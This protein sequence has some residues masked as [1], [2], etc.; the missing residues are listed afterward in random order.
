LIRIILVIVETFY[1]YFID[2]KYRVDVERIMQQE[3]LHEFQ[4]RLYE[5]AKSNPVKK[6][7]GIHHWLWNEDVLRLAWKTVKKNKGAGGI[8]NVT[9]SDIEHQGVAKFLNSIR[10]E[11]K[12]GSFRPACVRRVY[13][14]K[15]NG[16][17]RPL[18][19]TTIRDRVVQT[20]VKLVIEPVFEA[21]FEDFSYGFR[22]DRSTKDACMA[23][24][25]W[26][27]AGCHNVFDADIA[28][29]FDSIPH[30]TLMSRWHKHER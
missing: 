7:N 15:A 24:R 16:K 22:P 10:S 18:G 4:C 14:P 26:I 6:F 20:A 5:E 25:R 17:L 8:D 13:I 28:S 23:V 27:G 19:I 11:L 21:G 30:E 2:K 12:S 1:D 3:T 29:C 9:I